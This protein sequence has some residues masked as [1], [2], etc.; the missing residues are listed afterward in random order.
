MFD[1]N[2][3]YGSH[4]PLV[5]LAREAIESFLSGDNEVEIPILGSSQPK[6]AGCFVSL[7]LLSTG[8]LRGC[9]GTIEPTEASLAQ[10]IVHNA[11][12]A[13]TQDPRFPPVQKKELDDIYISVDVL[14]EPEP[15]TMD[16]LD[17]S[18]FGV[19]VTKGLKRGL[20]LPDL[21][22]VE[23]VEEQ[24]SIACMKAGIDP[25]SS[26][27]IERFEVVRHT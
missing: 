22:G 20:L 11:I 1:T 4:D 27:E 3:H 15:T 2:D 17:P 12:A 7:H 13:A 16:N 19:I 9:I 26:F 14:F 8:D 25:R 21:E 18:R 23:T 10:E 6:R 24:V 5:V